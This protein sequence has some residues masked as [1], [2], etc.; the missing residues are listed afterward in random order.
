MKILKTS[1]LIASTVIF[2][3]C[4]GGVAPIVSTPI[5]NID[6]LPLKTTPITD[7]QTKKWGAYDLMTDTRP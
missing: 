5:E 7:A 2:T 6:L 3:S 4:G 1:F